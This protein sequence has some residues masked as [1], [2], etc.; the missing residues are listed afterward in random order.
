MSANHDIAVRVGADVS[1]LKQGMNQGSKS[2]GRFSAQSNKQLKETAEQIARVGAAATAAGVAMFAGLYVKGAQVVDQQAKLARSVGSSVSS[3]QALDRAAGLAGIAADGLS[4]ASVSLNE[5]LGEA[6]RGA[7]AAAEQLERMGLSANDLANMEADERLAVLADRMRELRYNSAQAGDALKQF[8]ISGD[9][10][11]GLMLEGG[12]AFRSARKDIE[13][14]GIAVSDI[15]AAQIEAANDAMQSIRDTMQGVANSVAT[16]LSPSVQAVAQM[17]VDSA[18]DANGFSDQI[19]EGFDRMVVG[20]I[21]TA[22]GFQRVFGVL[23]GGFD[24][25]WSGFQSLPP[26]A[27]EVGI[28]GA[29]IGGKKGVAVLA[30][31]S[32]FT[33]DTKVTMAWFKAMTEGDISF[34]EWFNP[35][36]VEN[37][38]ARLAELGRDIEGFSSEGPSIVESLFGDRKDID[39]WEADMIARYRAVQETAARVAQETTDSR[40]AL[41]GLPGAGAGAGED[42][43]DMDAALEKMR[44]RFASE[45]ELLTQK[46]SEEAALLREALDA[47][48]LTQGEYYDLYE[49]LATDHHQSLTDIEKKAA[50]QRAAIAKAEADAKRRNLSNALTD[51]GVL[52]NTHSRKLFEIGKAAG[53]SNAII[54]THEGITAALKLPFPYNMAAAAATAAKGFASVSAIRSQSFGGGG[55]GARATG[56]NTAAVNAA[57]TPVGGNAGAGGP[58]QNTVIQLSGDFFG[59]TQVR[60]LLERINETTRNGGRVILG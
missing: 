28:A 16:V 35:Q 57:T 6:M 21:R 48:R 12:N 9:E 54:N 2:V 26:W 25:A 17:F 55:A 40:G 34:A 51:M 45:R 59:E 11:A 36:P 14:L 27:Q 1:S 41:P 18:R 32:K 31:A 46:Y 23:K 3:I 52:M 39:Q 44:E 13:E 10:I 24:D 50:D 49:Q 42:H 5:V 47:K 38:R 33:E 43:S 30:L 60:N 15:E 37:Y 4:G 29:M 8:G 22:A 20:G 58:Q 7:G 53:I 19:E 56:S